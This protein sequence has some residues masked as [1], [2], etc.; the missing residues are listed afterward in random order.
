MTEISSLCI[1]F[2]KQNRKCR[3]H[4]INAIKCFKTLNKEGKRKYFRLWNSDN[5]AAKAR[6]SLVGGGS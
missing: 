6:V 3:T 2:E 1:C 5:F 4:P